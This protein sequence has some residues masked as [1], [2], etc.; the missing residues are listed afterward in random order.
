MQGNGCAGIRGNHRIAVFL[1]NLHGLYFLKGGI[2]GFRWYN[3]RFRQAD[4]SDMV[5]TNTYWTYAWVAGLCMLLVAISGSW[6][7]HAAPVS[8]DGVIRQQFGQTAPV[9]GRLVAR[10]AGT[11]ASRVEG[12]VLELLVRIGDRV[13]KGQ[14]LA[15]IDTTELELEKAQA[16]VRRKEARA[17]LNVARSLLKLASQEVDRLARL[18]SSAAVSQASYD[19]A[20]QQQTI[21]SARVEEAE[22][23]VASTQASIALVDLKLRYSEVLA[24]YGG[25]VVGKDTEI[26]SYLRVGQAVVSLVSDGE[27]ELEADVPYRQIAGIPP[28]T[29]VSVV[30]DNG[31]RHTAHVRA[32]VPQE[33]PRTRTRRVRFSITWQEDSGILATEQ[34]VVVELPAGQARQILS[35]HKDGLIQRGNQTLVY[36]AEEGQALLRT[37]VTGEAIG[38]RVEVLGGLSEG[39]QVIIRGNER[40]TPGQAVTVGQSQW[41]Q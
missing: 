13:D 8:V 7:Q 31:S 15:R 25:T 23:A 27:L 5:R 10:Y 34:S 4:P 19:D 12:P 26:G 3:R 36:V 33:N 9:I 17:R 11:V 28:G 29:Q 6:A 40:L 18:Q 41:S 38:D 20:Q 14:L 39:D 32:V 16:T 21:A 37:I 24:P 30:L 35:T 22:T 1:V 2:A